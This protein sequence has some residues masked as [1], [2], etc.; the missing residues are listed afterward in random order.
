MKNSTSEKIEQALKNRNIS[1]IVLSKETVSTMLKE[2]CFIC[3]RHGYFKA[4][5]KSVINAKWSGCKKCDSIYLKEYVSVINKKAFIQSINDRY[6]NMFNTGWDNVLY[7]SGDSLVEM[8]CYKHGLIILKK[9]N[10]LGGGCKQCNRE[11]F[12]RNKL[13][14]Y[15]K[16]L[17]KEG[18]S[19][20]NSVWSG[21]HKDFKVSCAKH[22]EIVT[23]PASLKDY[24]CKQCNDSKRVFSG[25]RPPEYYK[26]RP[27]ILYLIEIKFCNKS[28]YKVG[29]S[30]STTKARY[31]RERAQFEYNIIKEWLYKDGERAARLEY[32]VLQDSIEYQVHNHKISGII[33]S[34]GGSSELRT[35]NLLE[36]IEKLR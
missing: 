8:Q 36:T 34:G 22:G 33:P 35:I 17:G 14:K 29:L 32:E 19:F 5:P 6:P 15:I 13:E 1:H 30:V 20:E 9:S 11:A 4:K 25:V 10:F 23:T 26:D 2:A 16:N 21:W 31:L 24:G 3:S 28:Y 12:F 18:F 27:V 7:T